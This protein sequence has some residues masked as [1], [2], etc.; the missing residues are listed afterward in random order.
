MAST[1][2]TNHS[3]AL[4]PLPPQYGGTFL[5]P[6][7]SAI[8]TDT[9]ANV[10]AAFGN[11]PIGHVEIKPTADGQQGAIAPGQSGTIQRRYLG[12]Q[13]FSVAGAITYTPTPGANRVLLRMQ[14]GG[15]GGGGV[16]NTAASNTAVG[17]GGASGDYLEKWIDP[18]AAITGG[19]GSVGAAGN[20][21]A[22]GG[23]AGGTGGDSTV[24]INGTTYT[25]KGGTGG[26]F[27]PGG[28]AA[29]ICAGGIGQ[30]GISAADVQV[31]AEAGVPGFTQSG[32]IAC[33]GEGGNSPWGS[34]GKPQ[35]AQ[36]AGQAGQGAGAGGGGALSINA[37]GAAA[38]GAGAAGKIIIDEYT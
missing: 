18:G 6:G 30:A 24:L 19:A 31:P 35:I 12:R 8:I 23:G 1:L 2:V 13:I 25:C 20:A 34:G 36:S 5:A 14:A 38:G 15:G 33:S 29:Q 32:T 10:S 21:G 28:T 9:V 11:P 27:T 17:G 26:S 22:S 3:P 7:Q 37:G 16:A 4:L